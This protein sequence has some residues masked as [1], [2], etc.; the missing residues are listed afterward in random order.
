M[1]KKSVPYYKKETEYTCGPASCRMVL[2][3]FGMN[4]TE[5]E[6][7][8]V[9]QTTL[10]KGTSPQNIK[11]LFD[12]QGFSTF[13]SSDIIER[14]DVITKISSLLSDGYLIIAL[15]NRLA[16]DVTT[17]LVDAEVEWE[18]PNESLHYIVVSSASENSVTINDPHV[19]VGVCQ[20]QHEPFLQS[21]MDLFIAVR[22]EN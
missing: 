4:N 11:K 8:D 3:Y 20:L 6:L 1:Q 15:V 5:Q 9:L 19:A 22:P 2:A 16:Y 21:W 14:T 12:Q 13:L 18:N 10:R 7:V 17:P